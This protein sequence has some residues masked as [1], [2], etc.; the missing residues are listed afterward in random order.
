MI[1]FITSWSATLHCGPAETSI[2]EDS[3]RIRELI[4]IFS[5]ASGNMN[6]CWFWLILKPKCIGL[7]PITC[8]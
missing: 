6:K 8:Y 1:S 5:E 7:E 3:T 2:F 4:N